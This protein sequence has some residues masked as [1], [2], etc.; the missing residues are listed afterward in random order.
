MNEG[1]IER[2]NEGKGEEERGK[3]RKRM[4]KDKRRGIIEGEE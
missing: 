4:K 3:E 1:E 2:R